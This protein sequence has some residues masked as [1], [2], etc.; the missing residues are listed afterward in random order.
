MQSR[1]P[2]R[3]NAAGGSYSPS[4]P[5][6]VTNPPQDVGVP[7]SRRN[8]PAPLQPVGAPMQM[9]NQFVRTPVVRYS[10]RM[11]VGRIHSMKVSLA[12]N[13][14]PSLASRVP[15][16]HLI[17][18]SS[19]SS[20]V[21]GAVV[22][23]PHVIVPLTGGDAHFYVQPLMPGKLVGAKVEFL[24]QGRRIGEV[25]L[26]MKANRGRL[27]KWLFF[28]ALI[29]PFV[30]NFFPEL[31][32]TDKVRP[33]PAKPAPEEKKPAK[34]LPASTVQPEEWVLEDAE[35]L[36]M[37][38]MTQPP[39]SKTETKKRRQAGASGPAEKRGR[40]SRQARG[41]VRWCLEKRQLHGNAQ[42]R[43]FPRPRRRGRPGRTSSCSQG[44][45]YSSLSGR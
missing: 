44:P 28:F 11:R 41:H 25:P 15:T 42:D 7:Y 31:S 6:F 30:I 24:S 35:D 14:V 16:G 1:Q 37:L 19:S 8:S 5:P 23:P 32:F 27:A 26:R 40:K 33:A 29:L 2:T 20:T 38:V 45:G 18:P 21:P 4:V 36:M 34:Q 9:S 10:S 22:T 39:K 12:T 3:G 43:P 17:R 13:G